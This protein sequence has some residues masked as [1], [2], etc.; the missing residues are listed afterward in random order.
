MRALCWKNSFYILGWF[1]TLASVVM[2]Y[3]QGIERVYFHQDDVVELAVV[4]DWQGIATLG[5]MNNEHLNVTFWPLLR[6]EWLLFGINFTP[7]LTLNIFLHVLVLFLTLVITYRL[8][9]SFLWASLPVWGMVINAN[10]FT[11]VWWITGQMFFLTTIFA[12]LSYFLILKIEENREK[13]WLYLLLYF[14]SV[15]PGLSWG[16]GLTWPIWPLLVFGIDYQ[17]R[18]LNKIGWTLGWS[19]LTLVLIYFS[20]VGSSLG[21][22]TDPK[23]W[24]SN[25][26]AFLTFIM[27]GISNTVVGRWLWPLEN[28]KI[29]VFC[30]AVLLIIIL[31]SKQIKK[32]WNK[33]VLFGVLVT[34]GSFATFALPRWRFGIGHAMANY[35]AYFPLPFL[36]IALAVWLSRIK[37]SSF[38]RLIILAVFLVHIPLS[39]IGFEEWASEWVVRPQQ[40]KSYFQ[41]LNK[42]LPGECLDKRYIPEYIVPQNIWRIDFIWP[43]FKKNFDP[44]CKKEM[45]K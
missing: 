31:V 8:T 39:W 14:V 13:K 27:V 34:L 5:H 43:I 33:Q 45:P 11:V 22:H 19:Q 36:L 44:F 26:L 2:L 10:W 35:Y 1:L 15:L 38:K 30:L 23:T 16:V 32:G 6:A 9:R 18:R 25:P 28:L 42:V 17:K 24:F 21:V 4:A 29:R 20:L 3:K 41:E 40:T 12:L 7:Y 37:L